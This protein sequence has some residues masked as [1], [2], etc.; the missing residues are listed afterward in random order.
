MAESQGAKARLLAK[1]RDR[2]R[3][4]DAHKRDTPQPQAERREAGT[5]SDEDLV[6]RRVGNGIIWS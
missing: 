6:K 2:R 4:K 1:L 3:R 5:E